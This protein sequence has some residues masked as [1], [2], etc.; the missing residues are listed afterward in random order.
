MTNCPRYGSSRR[1]TRLGTGSFALVDGNHLG[2]DV[3]TKRLQNSISPFDCHAVV[4]VSL[5]ARDLRFVY[6][7]QL[8]QFAL[9]DA[10]GNPQ[11]HKQA[12]N[13]LEIVK[14]FELATLQPLVTADL[15]FE[16]LME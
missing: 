4:L 13:T 10:F 1:G 15:L 16:L 14:F 6:L 8:S 12:A 5:V 9:T 2:T 7:E 3:H 11:S